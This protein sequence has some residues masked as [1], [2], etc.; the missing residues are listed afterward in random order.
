[1]DEKSNP[2]SQNPK[3]LICG[4]R[5]E[6]AQKFIQKREFIMFCVRHAAGI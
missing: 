1:M 3:G 4:T 5:D 6:K 2:L